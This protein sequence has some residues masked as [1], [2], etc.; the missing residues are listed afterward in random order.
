[1]SFRIGEGTTQS[2]AMPTVARHEL[3]E[4]ANCGPEIGSDRYCG[5]ASIA[6]GR[7]GGPARRST[8]ASSRP[9]F[10]DAGLGRSARRWP[11]AIVES[12]QSSSDRIGEHPARPTETG[13]PGFRARAHG[14]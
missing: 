2:A 8:V 6:S 10:G 9:T 14:M 12:A 4:R 5:D 1:V 11:A 7:A 13:A 3:A